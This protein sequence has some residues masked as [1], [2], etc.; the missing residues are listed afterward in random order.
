MRTSCCGHCNGSLKDLFEAALKRPH[1][2]E[3]GN[4]NGR[5]ADETQRL[6]VVISLNIQDGVISQADFRATTCAT[7]LAYCELLVRMVNGQRIEDALRVRAEDLV[8][9]V[10][11]VPPYRQSRARLAVAALHAALLQE[12]WKGVK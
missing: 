1:P 12:E 8:D 7:L 5:A 6:Q 3:F 4:R 9:R 2:R 11:G 10:R